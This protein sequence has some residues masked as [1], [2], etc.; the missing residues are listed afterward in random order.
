MEKTRQYFVWALTALFIGLTAA[1]APTAERRATGEFVDDAA[2]T[3]RVKTALIKSDKVNANSVNVDTYRGVVQL[4]GFVESEAM[5]REAGQIARGVDGVT[6]V[7]N[8]LRLTP[9]R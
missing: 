2:I 7:R 8:D 6:T 5:M 9:R 4:S 1:C 3:A